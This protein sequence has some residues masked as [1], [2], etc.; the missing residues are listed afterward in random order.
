[1]KKILLLGDS[2]RCGYDQYV[3]MAFDSVAEVYYPKE[4]CCYTTYILRGLLDWKNGL[5]CGDDVDLIHWNAGLWD[6]LILTDGKPLL[7]L[8]Q[9]KENVGRICSMAESLFPKAKMIFATSTPVREEMFKTYK[10][11]NKDTEAYNKAACETVIKHGATVNDLYSLLKD[12][13]DD[14]HSDMTHFYTKNATELICNQ[15]IA[16]IE[17]ALNIK[18]KKLDFNE[19]FHCS[20]EPVKGM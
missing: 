2:I 19:I 9:Y 14:Y 1:M 3:K 8:E 7:S 15:V 18:A 11:Y 17:D 12:V 20:I 4:N 6:D 5:D 16:H 13:P 10:R